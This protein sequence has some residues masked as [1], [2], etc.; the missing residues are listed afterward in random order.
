MSTETRP[1]L[2]AD[3]V[4]PEA[5]KH[6]ARFHKDFVDEVSAAVA[7]DHIVVVGMG[8]NPVVKKAKKALKD[9]GLTYTSID[10]GSYL[11]GYRR[12]LAIKLW[13]G[14]PT[15]PQ[16]FVDGTLIGGA[17]ELIAGIADGSIR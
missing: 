10:H 9:A 12:C 14:Y 1:L 5:A 11:S 13:S 2:P 16:V 4:S 15:F 8:Q 17:R 7:K 3:R 6:M